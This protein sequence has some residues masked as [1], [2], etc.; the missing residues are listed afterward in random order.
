MLDIIIPTFNQE[1]FTVRCFES[2]RKYTSDYRII[3][4]DNGSTEYSRLKVL[5]E[6]KN[7]KEYLT[8]WFEKNQGFV[9][10][11][12]AGIKASTAD[13]IVFMNNDTEATP[14]WSERLLYPLQNGSNYIASGPLT[15]T[16]GSWQGWRNV[17]Q[18]TLYDM[19]D[20]ANKTG[21]QISEILIQKYNGK[22]MDVGMIAFF[23]T[24]FKKRA[25]EL[26]GGLDECFLLGFGDDDDCCHR[27]KKMG[28]KI[29]FVPSAFVYHHH[30]TTF[31]SM[32]S[33]QQ[34]Q[35][36]QDKNL[37]IFKQKNRLI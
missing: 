1:D 32:F 18:K 22:I 23:C 28:H 16:D 10:G 34:I 3:W 9:K 25:F 31:K 37:K 7:H 35:A 6:L 17:K 14:Q 13:Y 2:I 12:N 27:L 36:M 29:A 19:P 20:L 21:E 11:T 33:Q 4:V 15:S 24:I 8:I 26:L 30:R 5:D